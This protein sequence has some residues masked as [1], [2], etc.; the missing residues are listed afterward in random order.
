M[1]CSCGGESW[2]GSNSEV[3][4]SVDLKVQLG[5]QIFSDVN[6]SEP[7]GTPCLTCHRSDTGFAGNHGGKDGIA[8][9]SKPTSIGLRN[10]M[11]DPYASFVPLF[12]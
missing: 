12:F 7:Q 11:T 1:L 8:M 4:P 6:L 9:G 5:S 10:T 2:S 3:T